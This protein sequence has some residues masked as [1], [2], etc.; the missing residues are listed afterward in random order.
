MG[1]VNLRKFEGGAQWPQ[2]SI[3]DCWHNYSDQD[4]ATWKKRTPHSLLKFGGEF[5]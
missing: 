4:G 2:F 1:Y 3:R 5:R